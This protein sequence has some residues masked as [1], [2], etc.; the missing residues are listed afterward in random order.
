MSMLACGMSNVRRRRRRIARL[1]ICPSMRVEAS[2][3]VL[4]Q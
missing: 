4:S 1:R 3:P 2:M